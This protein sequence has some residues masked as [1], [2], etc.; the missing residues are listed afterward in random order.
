MAFAKRLQELRENRFITRKDLA[1]ALNITISALGMYERGQREPN[2]D[3]LIKIAD[4]FNV[5][6]DFLIGRSFNQN[7]SKEI[8]NALNLKKKIDK[9]PQEYKDII[10]YMLLKENKNKN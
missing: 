9:L 10:E 7:E 3:M 2:I 5:S 6:V 1:V 4:Y 8:L